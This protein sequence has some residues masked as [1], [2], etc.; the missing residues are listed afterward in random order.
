MNL[1]QEAQDSVRTLTKLAEILDLRD[2]STS[3][4]L[5]AMSDV[6]LEKQRLE[7]DIEERNALLDELRKRRKALKEIREKTRAQLEGMRSRQ[8][9]DDELIGKWDRDSSILVQKGQE[10]SERIEYLKSS[11]DTNRS[12]QLNF[13]KLNNLR[14][15]IASMKQER[16]ENKMKLDSYQDLP[17]DMTLAKI[18][19]AEGKHKLEGLIERRQVLLEGMLR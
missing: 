8:Q 19:V 10:Y 15:E 4:Y 2:V 17:P 1:S 16:A 12:S 7:I 11:T 13:T 5:T 18:K 6:T 9:E 14:D 3:S